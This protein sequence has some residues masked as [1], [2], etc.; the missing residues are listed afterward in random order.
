MSCT[1]AALF[2]ATLSIV[3][4]NLR[5]H[6][7]VTAGLTSQFWADILWWKQFLVTFN[8]LSMMIDFRQPVYF[9]T[10]ASFHGFGA[11]S[12]DDWFAGS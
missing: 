6:H 7:T 5:A 8:G 2:F 1:E 12:S 10:D 11:V 9:Q 3:S 4:I